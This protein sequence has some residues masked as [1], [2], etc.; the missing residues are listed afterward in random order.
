MKKIV[1]ILFI[2]LISMYAESVQVFKTNT[3]HLQVDK[4][5][6]LE[7]LFVGTMEEYTKRQKE[8]LSSQTIKSAVGE[9]VVTVFNTNASSLSEVAKNGGSSGG[10]IGAGLILGMT[11][12]MGATNYITEDFIYLYLAKGTNVDN[13]ETLIYSL[14]ISNDKLENE[15]I[16]K[17]AIEKI[18]G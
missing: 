16:E 14:I 3:M 8:I 5:T 6:K 13:Q 12:V 2:G 1:T 11:A 7:K 18:K 9:S 4:N 10:L 17:L 15:E